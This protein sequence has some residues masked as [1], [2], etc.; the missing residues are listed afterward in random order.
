MSVFIYTR[1]SLSYQR[2]SSHEC[3]LQP[4]KAQGLPS[5]NIDAVDAKSDDMQTYRDYAL[6]ST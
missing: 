1:Q 5:M 4:Q 3:L 2:S 6:W